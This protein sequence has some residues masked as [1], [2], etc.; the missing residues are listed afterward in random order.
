MIEI[1]EIKIEEFKDKIYE[2]YVQL[3]PE[4]EQR[5]WEKIEN[6]YKEG[7]EKFY[8][9]VL[10]NKIIGFFM[11]EKINKNY[12]YYL[13]YFAI[14]KE[15]QNKG[16]GTESFKKLLENII[17]NQGLCI[18]IEKEEIDN[19]TTIKRANFYNRLGFKKIN[20]EY[21]LYKVLFTPYVYNYTTDKEVIDK[22]MFD[23][24]KM[25][26]GENEIKNRCKII[27]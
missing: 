19:Q 9:I 26:C 14:F 25:N 2:Q 16:Y 12:P 24:Y 21:L 6:S 20:S 8:K 3:F 10:D 22:I 23:Y 27:K 18:E 13:D 5:D 1:L 15:Y 11:L 4:E 7:F 17:V